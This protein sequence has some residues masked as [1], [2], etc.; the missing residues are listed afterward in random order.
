LPIDTR[1]EDP[2]IEGALSNISTQSWQHFNPAMV[3]S[4]QP[5]QHFNPAMAI[6]TQLQQHFNPTTATFQPSHSNISTQPWQHFNPATAISTQPQPFGQV[7]A[8][9]AQ[10]QFN[11]NSN[12]S[13]HQFPC[14]WSTVL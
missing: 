9:Q 10:Q 12:Q 13:H 8:T 2:V 5:Q 1:F 3:I 14:H 11:S 4:T 6:S 7:S